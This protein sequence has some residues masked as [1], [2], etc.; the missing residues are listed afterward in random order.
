[1]KFNASMIK[2]LVGSQW[3]A[4]VEISNWPYW[5]KIVGGL[6][7][8]TDDILIKE[9]VSIR[10]K[11]ICIHKKFLWTILAWN[12]LLLVIIPAITPIA[13][14]YQYRKSHCGD[15]TIWRPS[16]LH[17]GISYT[18]KMTSLYWIGAQDTILQPPTWSSTL[19][20]PHESHQDLHINTKDIDTNTN[21][22]RPG[23]QLNVSTAPRCLNVHQSPSCA[24]I[25]PTMVYH[26]DV[27]VMVMTDR[28]ISLL[29]YVHR[30]SHSWRQAFS[31][32]DFENWRPS[33][34]VWRK[35]K[36]IYW[37][38]YPIHLLPFYFR[39]VTPTIHEITI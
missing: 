39:P 20:H 3:N 19:H 25:H 13:T 26:G 5:K 11:Y 30:L 10:A 38:N 21:W 37:A 36:V 1:M 29:F 35:D 24:S 15:K 9:G 14:Y 27:M 16:Y 34:Q 8:P 2:D 12:E 28:F 4:V 7:I 6:A 22:Y 17:N 23:G 32:F 31:S 18:G 33:S